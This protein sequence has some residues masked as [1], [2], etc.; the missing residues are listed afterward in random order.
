MLGGSP[1]VRAEKISDLIEEANALARIFSASLATANERL[2]AT[3]AA[4]TRSPDHLI[5]RFCYSPFTA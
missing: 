3:D 1:H 4:I 5:T 2:I